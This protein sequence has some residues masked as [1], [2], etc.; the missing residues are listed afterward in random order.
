MHTCRIHRL[1][2][3]FFVL[4]STVCISVPAFSASPQN[5]QVFDT[6][7]AENISVYERAAKATVSIN[8]VNNGKP[9][10]GAGIIINPEGL[11][12]TSGHVI[13]DATI[14][15]VSLENGTKFKAQVIART[16]KSDDIA[17]LK[18]NSPKPLPTVPLASSS[19]LKVGQKV[20]AIGHPYGFEHTLTTGIISRLDV[21]RNRI[22]TDAAINPGCSG[23]PLLNSKG[24]LI[25]INVAIFNPN[26]KSAFVDRTNIGIAF[27]VPVNTVKHF[28]KELATINPLPAEIAASSKNPIVKYLPV[29]EQGMENVSVMLNKL[30]EEL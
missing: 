23:G 13:G 4:C 3:V 11:I 15:Y 6:D 27:S 8:A 19:G 26:Q 7:E 17:M 28:I 21:K 24:E 10:S 30:S 14:V 20:L 18:I 12:L 1:I 29:D 16:G 5:T 22:Q 25:G 9:S 2:W